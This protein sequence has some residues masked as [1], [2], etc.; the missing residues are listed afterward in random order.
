MVRRSV[1]ASRHEQCEL[2][3][4][5]RAACVD[6]G[7]QPEDRARGTA[8][9]LGR[10]ADRRVGALSI[11]SLGAFKVVALSPHSRLRTLQVSRNEQRFKGDKDVHDAHLDATYL[12]RVDGAHAAGVTARRNG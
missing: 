9:L 8:Q 3:L 5:R 7:A 11:F 6:T 12:T 4:Q 2:L 1:E 10:I